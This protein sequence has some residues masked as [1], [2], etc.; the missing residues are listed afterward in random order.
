MKTSFR[1][2]LYR[3][4]RKVSY[5][6]LENT[7]FI[8]INASILFLLYIGIEAETL[9][10]RIIPYVYRDKLLI[11][12]VVTTLLLICLRVIW[13]W[14]HRLR[15]AGIVEVVSNYVDAIIVTILL[16]WV[17]GANKT[18]M[19]IAVSIVLLFDAVLFT[20]GA[21]YKKIAQYMI[22]GTVIAGLVDIFLY[23][24]T[25]KEV[26]MNLLFI[27]A[28]CIFSFKVIPYW[29]ILDTPYRRNLIKEFG[30]KDIDKS[31]IF[32][33]KKKEKNK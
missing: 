6:K 28:G 22:Y 17:T 9:P 2:V 10:S 25:D 7:I 18:S 15:Y 8:M 16:G 21:I 19:S 5:N 29:L 12:Y 20:V 4:T 11:F 31:A 1:K 32:V 23:F 33:S 30:P 27:P 24:I 14:Y 26:F 13:S 3:Y